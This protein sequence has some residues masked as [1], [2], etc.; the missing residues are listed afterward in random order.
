[1][2]LLMQV[3]GLDAC[4]AATS[5]AWCADVLYIWSDA[6][7]CAGSGSHRQ[8]SEDLKVKP[9]ESSMPSLSW[10]YNQGTTGARVEA[11]ATSLT[12]SHNRSGAENSS[13]SSRGAQTKAGVEVSGLSARGLAP[14][15]PV[16]EP[17][18]HSFR[19][20][21]T[22]GGVEASGHSFR[23][24]QGSP[25][26][27]SKEASSLLTAAFM[28][29]LLCEDRLDF[30]HVFEDAVPGMPSARATFQVRS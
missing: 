30:Q 13:Q 18:S 20:N 12:A 27:E 10:A 1:M 17:S 9:S 8:A 11:S 28:P 14:S 16:V 15:R 2:T 24:G 5:F 7:F 26:S 25:G 21:Q 6:L 19:G 4:S 29:A 22:K 23:S 3:W